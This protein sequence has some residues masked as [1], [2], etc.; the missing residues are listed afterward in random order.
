MAFVVGRCLLGSL[1]NQRGMTQ[2]ELAVEL[3]VTRQ[4]VSKYVLNQQKMS[5]QTAKNISYIL[6]CR[7]DDLYEWIRVGTY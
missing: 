4:Q 7:I 3:G 6:N 1:L 5:L 2:T